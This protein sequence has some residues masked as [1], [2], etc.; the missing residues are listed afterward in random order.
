MIFQ[1]QFVL[2]YGFVKNGSAREPWIHMLGRIF[3]TDFWVQLNRTNIFDMFFV[4]R[5]SAFSFLRIRT[6]WFFS[7]PGARSTICFFAAAPSTFLVFLVIV[8]NALGP[9]WKHFGYALDTHWDVLGRSGTLCDALRRSGD[10]AG[11]LDIN[12]L[13]SLKIRFWGSTEK[14]H[15]FAKS[16]YLPQKW[17]SKLF[18]FVLPS[19]EM[20]VNATENPES[21]C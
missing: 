5:W 16:S 17:I 14:F 8:W 10:G 6:Y 4:Q 12:V 21:I 9:L 11:T 3:E 15:N 19:P 20:H 7:R 1:H 13:T 18:K 2:T